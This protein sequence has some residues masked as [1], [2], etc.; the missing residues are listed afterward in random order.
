M[1]NLAQ[2]IAR[3]TPEQRRLLRMKQRQNKPESAIPRLEPGA[4]APASMDQVALW[5]FHQMDPRSAAYN[6]GVGNR[7]LG[8]FELESLA[9]ALTALARR[10]DTLR[11]GFENVDGQ[12]YQRVADSAAVPMP[13]IDLR[14]LPADRREATAGELATGFIKTPF[15]LASPPLARLPV[16]VLGDRDHAL[17]AILHHSVTDW[18]S[19]Q[20]FFK[21]LLALY[22]QARGRGAEP[23]EGLPP[24]PIQFADYA[25]WRNRW[26]EGEAYERQLA[27]WRDQLAGAPL[28]FEV[29]G[30]RPRPPV[31]TFRGARVFYPLPAAL[32]PGTRALGQEAGASTLMTAMAAVF[33]LIHRYTG[34]V[35]FLVG[36]GV[37]NRDQPE[38]EGLIGYLLNV[39]I[40]RA[41]LSGRPSFRTLLERV[42]RTTLEAFDHRELP[43]RSLVEALNPPRDL[44]RQPVYQIEFNYVTYEGPEEAVGLR[45][46]KAD[47]FEERNFP[48]DRGAATADLQL[49]FIDFDDHFEFWVEYS[50]DLYDRDTALGMCRLMERLLAGAVAEPDTPIERISWLAGDERRRLLTAWNPEPSEDEAA[51]PLHA[52]FEASARQAPEDVALVVP[53]LDDGRIPGRLTYGDLDRRAA[54]VATALR[55]HGAGP[56][57]VVALHASRSL[58]LAAGLL[59]VL[60]AGAAYLPLD[61]EYPAERLRLTLTDS[62]ARLA[63]T[64]SHLAFPAADGVEVLCLDEIEDEEPPPPAALE[65]DH[66]AYVIYTSGSTGAPKGAAITH[67]GAGAFAAWLRDRFTDEQT[68]RGLA[69]A[70]IAFDMSVIELW[71]TW[72]R[73]GAAVLLE[74]LSQLHDLPAAWRPTL[75]MAAPSALRALLEFGDLPA[76]LQVLLL[77]GEAL[78][79]DLA[80]KVAEIPAR[81]NMYGPT[82]AT[83]CALFSAVAAAPEGPPPIGLPAALAR[84]HALDA[85]LEPAPVG[86]IGALHIGGPGLARG[87]PGRP[88]LTAERFIPDPWAD[89]PGQRL[90]VAGDRARRGRDG[91]FHFHGRTDRQ[92]KIRGYRVETA[93]IEAVL[94]RHPQVADALVL[95][96]PDD[97]GGMRLAAYWRATDEPGPDDEAL[98][99]FLEGALPA[100]MVPAGFVRLEETPLTPGGKVDLAALPEPDFGR[101]PIDYAAPAGD[102]ERAL[103]ELW[104]ELLRLPRVG[105]H[106]NFFQL[107]GDSI[108]GIVM[109][110]KARERGWVISL[111]QLF[112]NQTVA[113]LAALAAP[114]SAAGAESSPVVGDAPLTPIQSWFFDR[115]GPC[116]HWNLALLL[117]AS[118]PVD[119]DALEKAAR[120]LARR[121]DALRLRFRRDEGGSWRQSFLAPENI[122]VPFQSVDLRDRDDPETLA[123]DYVAR[124]HEGFNLEAGPLW[125]LSLVNAADGGCRV[126]WTMHHLLADT[127]SL[128]VL[129]DELDLAYRDLVAGGEPELSP[130]TA[131]LQAWQ[132]RL[133]ELAADPATLEDARDWRARLRSAASLPRDF[134]EA[135]VNDEA[136]AQTHEVG[137]SPAETE[138]LREGAARAFNARLE[139]VLLSA[140]ASALATWTGGAVPLIDVERH[141]RV[142]PR[143]ELDL[144]RTVGWLTAIAPL[145]VDRPS[146]DAGETLTAVKEQLRSLTHEGLGFG[147]LRWLGES[148]QSLADVDRAET[149][150]NYLGRVDERGPATARFLRPSPHAPGPFR[151]PAAPRPYPLEVTAAI[152]GGALRV[153]FAH[154]VH[155]HRPETIETLAAG[156]VANLRRLIDA[157]GEAGPAGYTPAD[158][159]DLDV[160]QA[161]LDDILDEL[162]G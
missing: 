98:R 48:V 73:G 153:A 50:V 135:A 81:W 121:H 66:L 138:S 96:R 3:L 32:T 59:G 83:V 90:Y 89:A 137:L 69:A 120:I 143:G 132:A 65:P 61:P 133:G 118:E 35:D 21:D 5:F 116:S 129:A 79:A 26:K 113:E 9:R 86:V 75:M 125:R 17:V 37:A 31:Q 117:V 10:H 150:F 28:V 102:A 18:W 47:D 33:A 45:K 134:A 22:R 12:L 88:D 154:S 44:S 76:S 23:I 160:N 46:R 109:I 93:E 95:A 147:A 53:D 27:Y 25:V 42:K 87:Y 1:N 64:E 91:A 122:E 74:N 103:A 58:H 39:L 141:G 70:T 101:G 68:A 162:G 29:A 124:A 63:L 146:D 30:D 110:A 84:V 123:A 36:T 158:F 71:T 55:R 108:V 11:T 6:I 107:G 114:A 148:A 78:P 151:A 157:C 2:R 60:K 92:V 56:D 130:K 14:A 77:G 128:G 99:V 94:R 4:P 106:D 13:V 15:D 139:E 104:A 19:F 100:H 16:F 152:E 115:V 155:L 159:P 40:M 127:V 149:A 140:L 126:L 34:A 80:A 41:D 82:E 62:G 136:S 7:I 144:S 105:V 161:E 38:T 156:V 49:S 51:P 24:L 119:A 111:K 52:L 67:R 54:S 20:N 145:A 72:S 131:S 57:V 142:D 8:S 43:F 112:Q 85:G 97:R